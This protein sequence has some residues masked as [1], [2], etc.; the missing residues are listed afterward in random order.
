MSDDFSLPILDKSI[1]HAIEKSILS[2]ESVKRKKIS[3]GDIS[4]GGITEVGGYRKRPSV[5]LIS[6]CALGELIHCANHESTQD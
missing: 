2:G 1:S 6:Q 3:A 5:E 4:R